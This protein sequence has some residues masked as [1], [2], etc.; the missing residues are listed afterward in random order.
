MPS[1]AATPATSPGFERTCRR[2]AGNR[3]LVK[4][5]GFVLGVALDD[6][7]HVGD[8]VVP[9][10]EQHVDVVPGVLSVL[11]QIDEPVPGAEEPHDE[12]QKK[13]GCNGNGDNGCCIHGIATVHSLIKPSHPTLTPDETTS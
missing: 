12:D 11:I 7:D 13:D 2:L 1:A 10:V 5:T 4:D 3:E 8:H 9:L 6:V